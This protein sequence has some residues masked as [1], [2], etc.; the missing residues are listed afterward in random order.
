MKTAG[1]VAWLRVSDNGPGFP[2]DFDATV[3]A[4]L[5]L[6][7]VDTLARHDLQGDLLCSNDGGATV[8]VTFPLAG[9]A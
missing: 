4:N 7:L 1:T 5:G 8:E 3:N 2:P 9:A 6:A